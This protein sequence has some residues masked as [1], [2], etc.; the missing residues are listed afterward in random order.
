MAFCGSR[1]LKI[2][3]WDTRFVGLGMTK[4]NSKSNCKSGGIEVVPQ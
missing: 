1:G 4:Q 2:E 3:T